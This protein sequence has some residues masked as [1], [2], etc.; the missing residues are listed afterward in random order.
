MAITEA[1]A[2]GK[3]LVEAS[4][5]ARDLINNPDVDPHRVRASV[6]EMMIHLTNAQTGLAE[7]QQEIMTLRAQLDDREAIR[8]LDDDLEFVQDGSFW[9]RKSEE[10]A[11]KPIFYCPAC[12]GD[13]KKL[14][15]LAALTEGCFECVIHKKTYVTQVY[16]DKARA[17]AQR[18]QRGAGRPGPWS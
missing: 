10:A 14:V 12:W 3:A 9:V 13:N 1:L 5:L 7:A 17:R 11:G 2:A 6:Q 15:P 4:K 8:A 18:S 16:H